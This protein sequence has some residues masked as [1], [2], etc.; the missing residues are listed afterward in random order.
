MSSTDDTDK[1]TNTDSMA[2]AKRVLQSIG[3]AV[4]QHAITQQTRRGEIFMV[5][6]HAC[7]IVFGLAVF[8]VAVSA[9]AVSP[10]NPYRTFNLGGVN[11]G[12]MRWEQAQRQGRRVWPYYGRSSR[13]SRRSRP[14][15]VFGG[16]GAAGGGVVT[17]QGGKTTSSAAGS[18][19]AT[20]KSTKS[21]QSSATTSPQNES[22]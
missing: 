1:V 12:S 14:T 17:R 6:Q 8:F 11:Y 2:M 20:S 22:D 19:I 10:R 16:I 18:G 7:G 21:P 5:R 15:I 4:I 9:E 13:S 3:P